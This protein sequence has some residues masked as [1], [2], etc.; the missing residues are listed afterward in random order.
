MPVPPYSDKRLELTPFVVYIRQYRGD[1]EARGILSNAFFE[2][3]RCKAASLPRKTYLLMDLVERHPTPAKSS[4]FSR[5]RWSARYKQRALE[6]L[7]MQHYFESRVKC[8]YS[9]GPC[10]TSGLNHQLSP[11]KRKSGDFSLLCSKIRR[12]IIKGRMLF[13]S[14][15]VFKH[16]NE[17]RLAFFHGKSG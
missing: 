8:V 9:Q 14:R 5:C 11:Q 15:V 10:A 16:E 1:Y 13:V 7:R 17:R 3:S 6:G 4:F 12:A 2:L